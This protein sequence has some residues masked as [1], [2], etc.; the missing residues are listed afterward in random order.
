LTAARDA[1]IERGVETPLDEI[2]RRAGVAIATLRRRF[3][4]RH[5]LKRAV[6]LDV[7]AR[8]VEETKRASEEEP[9]AFGVLVR[10]LHRG[11]ELRA[12]SL[13]PLLV[14]DLD[15]EADI[16]RARDEAAGALRATVAR[17]HEQGTLRA[18]IDVGDVGL[19]LVRLGRRLAH[20]PPAVDEAIARRQLDLVI[21][22]LRAA[23][24][25]G[26][27]PLSGPKLS[28]GE[29]RSIGASTA[30]EEVISTP[31]SGSGRARRFSSFHS[32]EDGIDDA[33]GKT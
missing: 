18:D 14:A 10:Y 28:F 6:A 15:G 21:D 19:I 4:D 30:S 33:E 13:F 17:A 24:N 20:L 27:E 11:L 29:L 12:G 32:L 3:A 2:A 22:G 9:D 7:W 31:R 26:I 5:A 1:F 23:P 8:L 25:R 16:A